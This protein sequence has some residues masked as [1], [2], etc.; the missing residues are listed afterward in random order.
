MTASGIESPSF[1]ARLARI[2]RRPWILAALLG[3][4]AIVCGAALPLAPVEQSHVSVAWPSADAERESTALLL[5]NQTPHDITVR[6]SSADAE[7]AESAGGT[8]FATVDPSR[9]DASDL[10]L[11]VAAVDGGIRISSGGESET[12]EAGTETEWDV[13]ASIHGMTVSSDGRELASWAVPPPQVDGLL[14]DVPAGTGDLAAALVLVDDVNDR[15]TPLKLA[16]L[17]IGALALVLALLALRRDDRLSALALGESRTRRSAV[18]RTGAA[19]GGFVRSLGAADAVVVGALTFWAFVGPMTDDDGYYATM[20]YNAAEAGYVGNYFQMFNQSYTPFTWL[21]QF[22]GLWQEWGGRSPV[23]LRVPALLLGVVAW[24]LTR[25]LLNEMRQRGRR[26]ATE[27]VNLVLAAVFVVWWCAY[28]MG[29]RPEPVAATATVLVIWA[30]VRAH[31][32]RALLPAALGVAVSA[33]AFAAHPIGIVSAAPLLVSL[34]ALWRIARE[35]STLFAAVGRTV[36]VASASSVALIAAFADGSL[37]DM[38]SGQ[39]RFSLVEI[40]LDWTD[41]ISRYGLLLGDIPMG[42]YAKRAVVLV[43]LVLLVWFVA[44]AAWSRSAGVFFRPVPLGLVGWSFALSFVLMWITTSKWTHHFG[45]LAAVGPLFIAAMCFVV[46]RLIRENLPADSRVAP[47]LSPLVVASLLPAIVLSLRGPDTWAYEW[48]ESLPPVDAPRILGVGLS[49]IY[50]WALVAVAAV[51]VAGWWTRRSVGSWRGV[52]VMYAPAIVVTVLFAV[53]GAYL[54]GSFA[55]MV[56]PGS[57]FTPNR[58]ALIDPTGAQCLPDNAIRLWD[59]AA[60]EPLPVSGAL[61]AAA[62]GFEA[63]T[64]IDGAPSQSAQLEMW[65]PTAEDSVGSFESGWFEY[66]VV[67]EDERVGLLVRGDLTETGA[68]ALWLEVDG[69][70]DRTPLVLEAARPGWST[71][72]IEGITPG[73]RF[74][75]LGED[76]SAADGEG[77]TVSRP[78]LASARTMA[79]MRTPGE[80][81]AVSWM[82]SWWFPCDRPMTIARGVVEPPVLATTFGPNG[83]DNIWVAT[84]GGSLAGVQRLAVMNTPATGLGESAYPAWGRVHLFDYPMATQAYD[85]EQSWT[86]TPGWRSSLDPASQTIPADPATR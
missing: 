16:V 82:Q 74:R 59:A 78:T 31:R 70:E 77:L 9:A 84:R 21:W 30:M 37:Y 27:G 20:G 23:W 6:F 76:E 52:G 1:S 4:A 8:I 26:I 51:V 18:S 50:V 56:G 69:A 2:V 57:G 39:Q 73:D 14:T 3:L 44:Y 60:G 86:V 24:F 32:N 53:T 85:L 79:E 47:W 35:R 29:A 38:L 28:S 22:F 75:L 34:P 36:A 68:S 7:A 45:S 83:L 67:A 61:T 42:S 33:L 46:P 13:T 58:A 19:I 72:V 81:T 55:R 65:R 12:W 43:G 11:V 63:G 10:G 41:E 71:V 80:P 17:A 54:L 62:D 49:N 66:P 5:T 15:P 48:G 25:A 64:A 40:P